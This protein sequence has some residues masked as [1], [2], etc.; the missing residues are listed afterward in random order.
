MA[1]NDD[2]PAFRDYD[3]AS[4]RD[5][6][7][8]GHEDWYVSPMPR[9]R[10]KQLM[11]RDDRKALLDYGLWLSLLSV[12]GILAYLSWGSWLATPAFLVYGVL[13]G[14]GAT[15]RLHE[16]LHRTP[17]K[18]LWLNEF[19][20]HLTGFMALRNCHLWRWSHTRHHSETVVVGRDPEIAYPRPPDLLG[21]ALNLLNLKAGTAEL[22]KTCRQALGGLSAAEKDFVPEA[23]R[24]KLIRLSRIHLLIFSCVVAWSVAAGSWLPLMFVGL[25][26]FYGA[27]LQ[28]VLSITQHAGLAEDMPDHRLNSRTV[29]LNPVFRFLYSNMNYHVEHHMYPM[30]PFHAL[31]ALHEEIK[32]DCPPP[33]PGL[34]SALREIGPAL[35]AQQRDPAHFVRRA[36]PPEA[37]ARQHAAA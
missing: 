13:Y 9:K 7:S 21:M 22:W 1:P 24:A 6:V 15:S 26:T 33:Y 35:I 32:A 16:C 14:S 20:V 11:K 12:A 5:A 25:P 31:P 18:S 37:A 19:F 17:F 34:L 29:L 23:E 3:L 36:L 2:S 4:N 10:L 8:L 27:W 30:V 28:F